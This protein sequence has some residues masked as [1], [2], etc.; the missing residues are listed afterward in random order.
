V[1]E[2]DFGNIISI[3]DRIVGEDIALGVWPVEVEVLDKG[4]AELSR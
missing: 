1:V 3:G 2:E 4:G